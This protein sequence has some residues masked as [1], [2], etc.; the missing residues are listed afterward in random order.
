M[1]AWWDERME[2]RRNLYHMMVEWLQRGT[3]RTHLGTRQPNRGL[4]CASL[5]WLERDRAQVATRRNRDKHDDS[6][7][8]QGRRRSVDLRFSRPTLTFRRDAV[9]RDNAT[10]TPSELSFCQRRATGVLPLSSTRMPPLDGYN[11]L[12][13]VGVGEASGPHG[14][15]GSHP[16]PDELEPV[17][18]DRAERTPR[19]QRVIRPPL[20]GG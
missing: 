20:F 18:S 6:A 2:S 12:R 10:D 1:G 14:A 16:L 13:G 19:P 5:R 11:G 9:T 3:R 15:E 8:G 17:G 4:L 7:S